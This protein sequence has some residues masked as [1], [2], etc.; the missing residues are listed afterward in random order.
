MP[1]V[2][3]LLAEGD[4]RALGLLPRASNYTFLAEVSNG[5]HQALAV[6]KPRS[7]EQPLWDFPDGTLCNREVAA[8]LLA[9]ALG[10]PAVPPTVLRDGPHGPGSVQLFIDADPRE[11]YFT[12]AQRDP[13]PFRAIAAFDVA[14]NNADRKGGHCLLGPDGSVWVVD[15]GVCFS[16]EPK[17]RTV[18]WDFAGEPLPNELAR[19][20]ERVSGELRSG[21]LRTAMIELLTSREVDAAARRAEVLARDGCFPRPTTGRSYPWPPV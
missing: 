5:T 13:T 8:H 4:L 17:L 3:A 12:L 9:R 6:Y 21:P 16:V 18:I 2:F 15:H 14:A 20:L 10:W 19:D 7:G 1:E 11:H